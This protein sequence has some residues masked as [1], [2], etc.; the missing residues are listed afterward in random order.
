MSLIS[1]SLSP[2]SNS[3]STTSIP[4][5]KTDGAQEGIS[6]SSTDLTS[7]SSTVQLSAAALQKAKEDIQAAIQKKSFAIDLKDESKRLL[8]QI[9]P[10]SD[11]ELKKDNEEVP[12]TEDPTLLARAKQ[13]TDFFQHKSPNPFSGMP[14]N[15]LDAITYDDSGAYTINERRAAQAEQQ[16]Q[17]TAYWMPILMADAVSGDHRATYKAALDY[18]DKM[19]PLERASRNYSPDYVSSTTKLLKEEEKKKNG[20]SVEK[21]VSANSKIDLSVET[22][23]LTPTSNVTGATYSKTEVT[24]KQSI[25]KLATKFLQKNK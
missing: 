20:N 13:A 23:N 19:S 24:E 12:D 3:T 4:N 25:R 15:Q 21:E 17:D 2:Q 7:A 8:D 16:T 11:A 5:G 10:T 6:V 14:R 1:N 22:L 18:Y 9:S